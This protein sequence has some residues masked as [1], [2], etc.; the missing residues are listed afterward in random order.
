MTV[1]VSTSSISSLLCIVYASVCTGL[2]S[3][4]SSVRGAGQ[5]LTG[6]RRNEI[7][8]DTNSLYTQKIIH[9]IP[10]LDPLTSDL[11]PEYEESS[12]PPSFFWGDIDGTNFLSPVRNQHI[13]VYCGSCWAHAST[14]TMTDRFT[15]EHDAAT[16]FPGPTLLS[17]QNVIDCGDSGS[18]FGGWDGLVYQYAEQKG[19]PSETCNAYQAINQ[20]CN[21]MHECYTCWPGS[22]KG[23]EPVTRYQRMYAKEHG[24]VSGR[25]MMKAELFARGPI[26]CEI[27]ATEGLDAYTGGVYREFKPGAESNHVVS[28]VGWG[29]TGGADGQDGHGGEEYWIV[30]NSWGREYGEQGYFRIV[31]SKG[32]N[33]EYNLAIE[34]S[35]GWVSG[36]EWRDSQG[37][38][39]TKGT[40]GIVTENGS[41]TTQSQLVVH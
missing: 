22:L 39:E 37:E 21:R 34:E 30:R 35:C 26:S 18:C 20:E 1:P 8:R 2:A 32:G 24:R 33:G 13:P 3:P 16:K 25:K 38:R 36:L 19:I 10:Y 31:T 15:I 28:I 5:T 40:F 9:P 17:V 29:V 27:D 11:L 4:V 7:L 41:L 6:V 14:S 12:L 23:C